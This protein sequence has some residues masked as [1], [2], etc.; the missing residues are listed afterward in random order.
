M[1]SQLFERNRQATLRSLD[2]CASR[3]LYFVVQPNMDV[4]KEDVENE[5]GQVK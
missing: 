2:L 3:D 4:Y 1:V 5:P